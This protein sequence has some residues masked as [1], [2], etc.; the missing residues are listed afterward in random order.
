MASSLI[1][2]VSSHLVPC[3]PEAQ[4]VSQL[5]VVIG[6]AVGAAKRKLSIRTHSKHLV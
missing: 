4:K 6:I 2:F 5:N 1:F 3:G